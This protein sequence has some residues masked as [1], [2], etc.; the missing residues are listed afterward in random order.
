MSQ[1]VVVYVDPPWALNAVGGVDPTRAVYEREV[2]GDTVELRLGSTV[3]GRF[4]RE[5]ERLEAIVRGAD[6]LVIHRCYITPELLDAVGDGLKVVGRLGVGFDNLNP[7][8]LRERG[9]IGFNVPDYCIDEV[10]VHT[11]ALLLA[12]ER[13]IIPQHLALAGGKFDIYAGGTPRRLH[14]RTAGIIGFG[15]IGRVVANRLRSFYDRVL[16]VDPYVARDVVEAYGARSVGFEDLLLEAD[17]VLLHCLLNEETTG[18]ID[19]AAFSL[20]KPGALLVNVA[21]GALVQPKPLYEALVEGHLGGAG[22]DVF[23]PEDPLEDE[24][25]A[26][27]VRLPNVVVTSHRAYLSREAEASQRRRAAQG[28]LDTL[29]TG[30]APASGHLTE[31]VRISWTPG[32]A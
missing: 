1:P 22:L 10:A 5:G 16:A 28:I 3:G 18:M 27:V 11:L 25:Y 29:R 31:G 4:V 6:A 24:W 7:D 23:S 17:V 20:M 19:A 2:F 12:L 8:L 13:R 26:R 14:E 15:R 9:I 21:R 32:V 30:R